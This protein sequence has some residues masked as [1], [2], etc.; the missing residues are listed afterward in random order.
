M[1]T[2]EFRYLGYHLWEEYIFKLIT[3]QPKHNF[4]F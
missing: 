4:Y 1:Y 2:S 3:Q